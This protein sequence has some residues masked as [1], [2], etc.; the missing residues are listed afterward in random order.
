MYKKIFVTL[1]ISVQALIIMSQTTY[2]LRNVNGDNYVS[3]VKSQNGGTCWTHGIMAAIEGNL[4]LTGI[5]AQTE[6]DTVGEPNMAEYH[7]DW[8]NGFNKHNNDDVSPPTGTGLDV[9]YGGDYRVTAA[10]ISRGESAVFSVEANDATE[11]DLPWYNSAPLRF[12]PSYQLFYPRHIEW[13]SVGDDLENIDI[14]KQKIIDHGV[15]GTCLYWGGGFYSY[16]TRTH[17]QPSSDANDPNHAVAIIGWDDQK[18]T[19]ASETGA[20]L[21][22]NSWGSGW[23]DD[24]YFWISYYDKHCGKHPEMGA[25]SFIDM[26]PYKYKQVFYHDYHGM[27]DTIPFNEG[28]NS[29]TATDST[30]LSSVSFFTA[31]DSIYFIA[32]IFDSFV[33][34]SLQDTLSEIADSVFHS[35]FHTF[36]LDS[37]VQLISGNDFYIYL[38]LTNGGQAID[39]TSVIPVLLG[40][41]SRT[42]VPSSASANESY[43]LENGVWTDLYNYSFSNSSWDNTANLCIKGLVLNDSILWTGILDSDWSKP[44]N[45]IPKISPT[46]N[47]FAEIP[48]DCDNNPSSSSD[49]LIQIKKLHLSTGAQVSIPVSCTLIIDE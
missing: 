20:W 8:W 30:I 14:V 4:L 27:R 39:R 29:F 33:N 34:G 41:S 6:P 48:A 44:G 31:A 16:T 10:Y 1:L 32:I 2:D 3:S 37:A 40:A 19:Q 7:L 38:S 5:W 9:H 47:I 43:Y 25:I 24:G 15:M 22:K 49:S 18:A 42:I 11:R 26:E 13:Y 45:W 28:F 35:G 23:G 36:D 21:I 12:D 46:K 17:Y